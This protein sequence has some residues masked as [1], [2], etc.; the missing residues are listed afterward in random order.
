MGTY[1]P[2]RFFRRAA[3]KMIVRFLGRGGGQNFPSPFAILRRF[4]PAIP[5]EAK[6]RN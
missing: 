5:T 1:P 3:Q 2:N 4:L 6:I